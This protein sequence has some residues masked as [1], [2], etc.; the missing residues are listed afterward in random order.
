[1]IRSIRWNLSTLSIGALLVALA[2]AAAPAR[3]AV[4]TVT[5][6]A[7]TADGA[8]DSDCSLR[9]AILAANANA[10]SDFIL[11]GSGFYTLTLA[12]AGEDLGATGDLDIRDD[13]AIVGTAGTT[14]IDGRELD[15]VFD[16]QAGVHLDLRGVT[17]Q[18]G[19]VAGPGGGIRN[20]GTLELSRSV[21]AVNA[22]TAGGFG[23][24]IWSGGSGSQLTVTQST[25]ANNTA[26]GGGGGLALNGP[27]R[28]SD[29][30]LSDNRANGN[31]GGIYVFANTEAVFT[32][33]TVAGDTAVKSG[34]GIFAE[35]SPFIGLHNPEFISS[36]LAGNTGVPQRDCAGTVQSGGYNLVGDVSECIDLTAGHHDLT[37]V[38]D[39]KL[40]Q[41]ANYGGPTL[42]Q[43]LLAGSPA[44]GKSN[45]CGES[46]QRGQERPASGCDI[47]AF[48]TGSH[49]LTG[50]PF[51]CLNQDRFRVTTTWR[52][53][54]GITGSGQAVKL[55]DESGYFGFFSF[56][57]VELTVKVLNACGGT[58]PRYWVFMSGMTNLAVTVTVTDTHTGASKTYQSPLNSIFPTILDTNAFATCP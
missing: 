38:L 13:V 22:T 48:Q 4:Y 35:I 56:S 46:D 54:H 39:P 25:V 57:N 52:T 19:K 7:D 18:N 55:G 24:G 49:C 44:L 5:K 31:G 45:S 3:A 28:V 36:I 27:T 33:V 15:R 6:T 51:L 23:G 21:V 41:L 40:G 53:Q 26:D 42:T 29:T 32:G 50:G 12:G 58:H 11:L 47:G 17:V 37:G 20:A 10:G 43:A 1:M 2:A 16:V 14:I 34:G 8:C 9:E 30:T